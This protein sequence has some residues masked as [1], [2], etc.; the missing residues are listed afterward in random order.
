MRGI[1]GRLH[2]LCR[3]T[4]AL[5][6]K[7]Q[8]SF[9]FLAKI[10]VQPTNFFT[11][12]NKKRFLK[13]FLAKTFFKLG[14]YSIGVLK[15]VRHLVPNAT[16]KIIYQS[17]VQSHFDYCNVVLGN[18]GVTLQNKLQKLQNRAARVWTF[19]DYDADADSL[20]EVLG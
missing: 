4:V 9:N 12:M 2:P 8:I 1:Q 5:S 17:L 15:R 18:C 6:G 10:K 14:K 11:E 16:L 19:S 3:E 20:F 13:I 7:L